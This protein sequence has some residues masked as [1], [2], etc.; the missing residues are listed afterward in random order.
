MT[1]EILGS[2]P[3]A[4]LAA[5]LPP[6]ARVGLALVAATFGLNH[7]RAK[8]DFATAERAFSLSRRWYDGEAIEPQAI[9]DALYDALVCETR[10]E[11]KLERP[12][13]FVLTSAVGYTAFHAYRARNEMVGALISELG[14]NVLDFLNEHMDSLFPVA[15]NTLAGVAEYIKTNPAARFEQLERVASIAQE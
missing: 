14:E 15:I 7:L 1:R 10:A 9:E 12:A 11:E 3:L 5:P 13:W 2:G 6:R 4:I 8:T